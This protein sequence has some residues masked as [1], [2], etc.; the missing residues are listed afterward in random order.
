MNTIAS[1]DQFK[2]LE[3]E[4]NMRRNIVAGSVRSLSQSD[5]S[6]CISVL[7]KKSK[8]TK[9]KKSDKHLGS[10]VRYIFAIL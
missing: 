3:S 6:V 10:C 7:V 2:Q 8:Q 4:K 5:C 9:T 1:R